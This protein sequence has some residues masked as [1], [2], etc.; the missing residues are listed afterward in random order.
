M[1]GKIIKGI[2]GF[3]Y[4]H[5]SEVGLYECKA[6]GI[7]RNKKIKPL[8]G[9]NV[10]IEITSELDFKGNIVKILPRKN[11]LIRPLVANIDQVI[12]VFSVAE[13]DP[14]FQLLD[15]FIVAI[16]KSSIDIIICFNKIDILNKEMIKDITC[17]YEKAGYIVIATSAIEMD[18][19]DTLKSMLK[20]KTSVFA[21]PSGVGKSS[22]LNDL[23]NE[24][25]M[26]T[27]TISQKIKRG[28]HTTRHVELIDLDENSYIVD[29]PGFSSIQL[30]N[31]EKEELSQYFIEFIKY[32]PFC[33]FHGCAHINEP[34]CGV[35]NALKDN[36]ISNSRYNSYEQIYQELKDQRK[37]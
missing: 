28:K 1:V 19:V 33:K 13:P 8:V 34:T 35:K 37:W 12:I 29:T 31:L 4:V 10:E 36:K 16:E 25:Y 27:G 11:E 32:E 23:Q 15:R 22:L 21:G 26:E 5:V 14:N 18:G 24:V 7:F 2:A 30:N 6:K 9:D 3:Y 20:A 17:I